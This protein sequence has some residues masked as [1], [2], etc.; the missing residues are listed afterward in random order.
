[1]WLI[2]PLGIFELRVMIKILAN[3]S[4]SRKLNLLTFSE[5]YHQWNFYLV[6]KLPDVV[7]SRTYFSDDCNFLYYIFSYF[8]IMGSNN[9]LIYVGRRVVDWTNCQIACLVHVFWET[10]FWDD[11]DQDQWSKIT[12]ITVHQR[13]G[14]IHS[15]QR[16]NDSLDAWSKWP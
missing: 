13:G 6:I 15:G 1:M 14:W 11:L 8:Y 12:L 7:S 3:M 4:A 10:A 5:H 9:L 2:L 16:S